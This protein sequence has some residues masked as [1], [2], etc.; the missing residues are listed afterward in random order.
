MK[1]VGDIQNLRVL[2][3]W[4]LNKGMSTVIVD[5]INVGRNSYFDIPGVSSDRSGKN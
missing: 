5:R 1:L 4:I 3:A 2:R